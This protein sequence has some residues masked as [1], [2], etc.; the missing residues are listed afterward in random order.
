MHS[1]LADFIEAHAEDIVE[2][3]VTFARS[4]HNG[5]EMSEEEL[6]D[7]LPEIIQAIVADMRTP[8]TRAE[9][10]EKA[11]GRAPADAGQ[12][13]SPAGTHAV[14]R[15]HSGFSISSLVAEY[16]AMR[17]AVL[18]MWAESPGSV[19]RN[20]EVTR[21]NEA[22]DQAIA[23]SVS[24]YSEEVDRWRNIFLGV[25]G[26]DLR[27]PLTAIMVA[28]EVIAGMAV[29]APLARVA[30]RL[31]SSGE[32]MGELLD[33]LLV[34]NRA[35]MGVG[36]EV[37]KEEA[38]LAHAC[39]EEIEQLQEAM[40]GAR[41]QLD[42]PPAARGRFDVRSVC[43]ALANLV[44]NAYKYGSP[45]QGIRVELRDDGDGVQLSVANHGETIPRDALQL[46]FEPLRRGGVAEEGRMERASLGLGLFIVS[47]IA[48]AHGGEITA[49]SADGRTVFTMQLPK[50]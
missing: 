24:H 38:D 44:V 4:E 46:L 19:I 29:D 45:D 3:A 8:Q 22:I 48:E 33:K 40:P 13:R 11:E 2:H 15:A 18:R 21:F 41:I 43:E 31:V 26:H 28:S 10:I 12:P 6:R 42:A 23:E 35:Q 7:H 25:L 32:R 34:Y 37:H 49:E 36:L 47:Q 5:H 27:S 39:R 30:Q 14:H 9:S 17:A 20:E 1:G 16:R 50:A